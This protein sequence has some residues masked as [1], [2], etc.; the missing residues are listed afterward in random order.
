MQ[1]YGH[2]PKEGTLTVRC[3][4]VWEGAVYRCRLREPSRE[5]DDWL[6]EDEVLLVEM[7]EWGLLQEAEYS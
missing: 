7:V 6:P 1:S 3:V 4:C 5:E 2:W